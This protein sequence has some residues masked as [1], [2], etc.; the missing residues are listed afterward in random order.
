MASQMFQ[1]NLTK[2]LLSR[3]INSLNQP[4]FARTSSKAV[5]YF[6]FLLYNFISYIKKLYSSGISF[7]LMNLS[8]LFTIIYYIHKK[9]FITFLIFYSFLNNSALNKSKPQRKPLSNLQIKVNF[10]I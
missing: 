6:V 2:I 1:Q 9:K 8:S 5:I 3:N 4:I 7:A 10:S